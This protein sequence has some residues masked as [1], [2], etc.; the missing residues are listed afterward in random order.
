MHPPCPAGDLKNI[1]GLVQHISED[2]G[3]MVLPQDAALPGFNEVIRFEPRELVKF[4]EVGQAAPTGGAGS[5]PPPL[6][7]PG[8][9]TLPASGTAPSQPRPG[10][11][12]LCSLQHGSASG[13][14]RA[15]R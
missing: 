9:H 12:A 11:A 5:P 4:F 3:V 14:R 6:S 15:R 1:K 8:C 2:G 13:H 10:C 7:P